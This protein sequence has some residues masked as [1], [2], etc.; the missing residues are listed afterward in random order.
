MKTG[1]RAEGDRRQQEEERKT[2]K[3]TPRRKEEGREWVRKCE[4]C[5][6]QKES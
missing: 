4:G 6:E 3:K 5:N 1:V 2:Q